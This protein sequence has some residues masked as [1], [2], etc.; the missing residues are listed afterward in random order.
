MGDW[1]RRACMHFAGG[2]ALRALRELGWEF[3]KV[4]RARWRAAEILTS[5][6]GRER[7]PGP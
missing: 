6:Y 7:A 1:G 5:V 4:L 2:C 3:G